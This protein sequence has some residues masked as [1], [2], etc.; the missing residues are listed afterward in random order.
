MAVYRED[1][2]EEWGKRVGRVGERLD[3]WVGG[4]GGGRKE[5]SRREKD[6][7]YSVEGGGGGGK[8]KENKRERER[9]KEK[10]KEKQLKDSEEISISVFTGDQRS[11]GLVLEERSSREFV[12]DF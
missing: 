2:D 4:W 8:K 11:R 10:E 12:R 9:E 1:R 7:L 5:K 3:G 6:T